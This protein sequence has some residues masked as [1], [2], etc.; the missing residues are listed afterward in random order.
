M[1]KK[2]AVRVTI[3]SLSNG[4]ENQSITLVEYAGSETEL[5]YKHWQLA[6]A[7]VGALTGALGE[8]AEA[9]EEGGQTVWDK[10]KAAKNKK[11]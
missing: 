6:T 4:E 10:Q 3:E 5:V 9:H 1:S 11:R 7:C 8:M 2:H